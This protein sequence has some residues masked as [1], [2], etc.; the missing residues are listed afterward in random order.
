MT[1]RSITAGALVFALAAV[2]GTLAQAQFFD[3]PGGFGD[4]GWGGW[5]GIGTHDSELARGMGVF[6]AGAG[7]YN[8]QTAI[9]DSIN[10]DTVMRWNEYMH[11]VQMNSGRILQKRREERR[12]RNLNLSDAIQKRLR[13]NPEPRDVLRGDALNVAFDEIDDPR[14]YVKALQGAKVRIGGEKIRNIPF[15]YAAA[16]I[17]VG[18]HQ[19]AT[20]TLPTPLLRPDFEADREALKALDQQI[21]EQIADDKDPD[22]ATVK[23]LLAA[24]YAIEEKAAKILPNNSLE[25]KQADKYLK[26]LHG[27]VVMLKTPAIDDIV[28][29]VEKRPDATLGEL[30]SFMNAF[31]LRFGVASTPQQQ[32]VYRF[33]YPKLVELRDQVAPALA[34][35]APPQPRGTAAEDFFSVL[36]Y[37]DLQKK[38]PKPSSAGDRPQ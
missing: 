21:F 19:L 18:I 10:T 24:I 31:N 20:G 1:R 35:S 12:E 32:E 29:G 2:P 37:D 5:G 7:F 34:T 6:A 11:E 30:L 15:R 9:A 13:D 36:S 4:F 16:A 26:A 33:L 8:K 17:T 14:V 23:K 22:P 25:R 27:L 3:Y 28:A 38:A